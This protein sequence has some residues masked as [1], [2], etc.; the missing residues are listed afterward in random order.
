MVVSDG[1]TI[2]LDLTNNT[3]DLQVDDEELERR[4]RSLRPREPRYTTGMLAKYAKLVGSAADG[5]ICS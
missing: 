2:R 1:A 5:A 4:R 3:L